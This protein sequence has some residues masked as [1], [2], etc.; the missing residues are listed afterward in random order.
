MKV[1]AHLSAAGQDRAPLTGRVARHAAAVIVAWAS[2][3]C[4]IG[5]DRAPQCRDLTAAGR[6]ARATLTGIAGWHRICAEVAARGLAACLHSRS[7]GV[8]LL[9]IAYEVWFSGIPTPAAPVPSCKA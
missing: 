5:Q 3:A 2:G 9:V 7:C 4:V 6:T 8:I 1:A